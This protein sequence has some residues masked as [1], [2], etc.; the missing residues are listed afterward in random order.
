MAPYYYDESNNGCPDPFDSQQYVGESRRKHTHLLT[1][2]MEALEL[3]PEI[4]HSPLE[5]SEDLTI[6]MLGDVY[7]FKTVES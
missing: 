7:Q 4:S 6:K 3:N 2:P 5:N 1:Y